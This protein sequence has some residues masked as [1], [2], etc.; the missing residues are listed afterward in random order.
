MLSCVGTR[1]SD[2]NGGCI[3]AYRHCL[4]YG[5]GHGLDLGVALG[6]VG[7]MRADA[8][9]LLS[10]CARLTSLSYVQSRHTSS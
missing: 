1:H 10:L 6:L 7:L 5:L 9:A 2:N 8:L 3:D 4:V